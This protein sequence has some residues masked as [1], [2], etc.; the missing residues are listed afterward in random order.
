MQNHQP[1]KRKQVPEID[2]IT[3]FFCQFQTWWS[4]LQPSWHTTLHAEP[5]CR[6]S[7][8]DSDWSKLEC[9]GPNSITLI[10]LFL[11]WLS[12]YIHLDHL[13]SS[14]F[15]TYVDDAGW[16]FHEIVHWM[17]TGHHIES[18]L[19]QK[20]DSDLDSTKMKLKLCK[21]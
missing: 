18:S 10:V 1:M 9:T 8:L 15:L 21:M 12:A 17:E 2:D 13:L 6:L 3:E 4:S 20:S 5:F 16:A 19:K 14:T 7:P 11:A